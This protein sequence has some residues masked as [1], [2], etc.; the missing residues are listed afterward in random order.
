MSFCTPSRLLRIFNVS[1]PRVY[2]DRYTL[3]WVRLIEEFLCV[4]RIKFN[5]ALID[6]GSC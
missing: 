3:A 4:V 1:V 6:R 2:A 5:G